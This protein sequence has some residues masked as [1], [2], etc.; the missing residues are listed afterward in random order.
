MPEDDET[1]RSGSTGRGDWK[2]R[3]AT[4]FLT[5]IAAAAASAAA[6]YAVKKAPDVLERVL[7][8]LR[9]LAADADSVGEL[10]GRA[11]SAATNAAAGVGDLAQ[12]LGGRAKA[13]VSPGQSTNG[14]GGDR[15]S[16]LEELAQ[17]RDERMRSREARR[18]ARSS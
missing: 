3:L 6:G 8:K 16:S 10:P 18:K 1:E 11:A 14:S 5:P 2:G 13:L 4:R 7:P 17:R 15:K 9:S 12:D